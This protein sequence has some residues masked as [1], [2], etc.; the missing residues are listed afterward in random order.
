[1]IATILDRM[2]ERGGCWRYVACAAAIV[3]V[4]LQGGRNVYGDPHPWERD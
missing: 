4:G 1:M 3:L 2:Y